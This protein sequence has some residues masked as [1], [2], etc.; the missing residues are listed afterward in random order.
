MKSSHNLAYFS[1]SFIPKRWLSEGDLKVIGENAQLV[2]DITTA[3]HCRKLDFRTPRP[4]LQ[5]EHRA[6]PQLRAHGP[7]EA[8]PHGQQLDFITLGTLWIFYVMSLSKLSLICKLRRGLG[9]EA[10]TGRSSSHSG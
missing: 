2:S 7:S 3:W 5:P 10:I 6:C 1:V 8:R 9:C 4:V